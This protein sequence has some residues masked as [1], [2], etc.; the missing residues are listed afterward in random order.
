MSEQWEVESIG[1]RQEQ[2]VRSLRTEIETGVLRDGESLPST[3]ALAERW[4][5]SV[6]TVNEA[7]KVLAA[8]GRIESKSRSRRTVRSDRPASHVRTPP[9]PQVFMIGGYAGSG[10]TKLGRILARRT[11]WPIIDKD[12]TTRPVVETALE[13][14]GLP[15]HD[16]ESD[17]YLSVIR[18][19]EYDALMATA[20]ENV[21]CGVSAMITAPFLREFADPAWL[22]R[23]KVEFASHGAIT[24]L[25]WVRCDGPTMR[26]NLRRRGSARDAAK[27]AAWDDYLAGLDL[28]FRPPQDHVVIDNS[29]S[30][31]TLQA[32]A[33]RLL[34]AA[35]AAAAT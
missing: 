27:L 1:T 33:V 24:T 15:P 2:I 30:S 28:D 25:V 32:Q 31:E 22:D 19:S 7:M 6:F 16:R 12:T 20:L 17:T 9:A 23:A 29:A 4:G 11:G 21:A 10:K 5:V 34:S 8:E 14:R 26:T 35:E 18:P 3:R 13:V